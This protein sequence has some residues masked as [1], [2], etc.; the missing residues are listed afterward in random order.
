MAIR[1]KSG[2]FLYEMPGLIH[3][4][5]KLGQ[6]WPLHFAV[7]ATAGINFNLRKILINTQLQKQHKKPAW[8]PAPSEVPRIHT[9]FL[10]I[11]HKALIHHTLQ[12][13]VLIPAVAATSRDSP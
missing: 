3:E 12:T 6:L 9:G 13:P 11:F 8:I 2:W 4:M 5:V 10:L 7:A 1:E